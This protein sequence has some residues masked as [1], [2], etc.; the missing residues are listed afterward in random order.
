MELDPTS[1]LIG[2]LSA[3]ISSLAVQLVDMRTEILTNRTK[4]ETRWDELVKQMELIHAEYRNVKHLERAL[5]VSGVAIDERLKIIGS[6]MQ[7]ME[8]DSATR[9]R[10][11][12]DQV[13]EWRTKLAMLVAGAA[14]IGT[15]L[16][17]LLQSGLK[18]V[19][20]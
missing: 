19:M 14:V 6:R 3:Q 2:S 8:D 11:L 16:S 5:E 10:K 15:F 7:R 20:G 12:E 18:K 17:W 9:L 1:Q 13:L 4:T